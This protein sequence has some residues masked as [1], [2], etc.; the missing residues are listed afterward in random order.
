[1]HPI[2][3]ILTL[4]M[5]SCEAESDC[6]GTP[7]GTAVEDDCAQCTEGTTGLVANNLMDCSGDCGGDAVIDACGVCGG[8]GS[9]CADCAGVPNGDSLVDNCGTCDNDSS[10]D[11]VEDCAG[12]WG[13]TLVD[14]DCGVCDGG[15][16]DD[17]GC[18][19]FEPVALEYWYDS[20]G[21][22]LGAGDESNFHC[23]VDAP[24]NWVSNNDDFEPDCTT[25]NTDSCY[26]CEG[27]IV[28]C[29]DLSDHSL[30][31]NSNGDLYYNSSLPIYGFQIDILSTDIDVT[32]SDLVESSG[33]TISMNS[34]DE[35]TR[36]LAFS[37]DGNSI[38]ETCGVLLSIQGIIGEIE[39]TNLLFSTANGGEIPMVVYDCR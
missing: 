4:V 30:H 13:G 19:C 16:S 38:S 27:D 20:D 14:D 18:G 36:I 11:C 39:I 31:L 33:L 28:Y 26:L 12:T 8:D 17:L 29:E 22:G 5:F 2:L 9:S 25:N 23:L 10:N 15:N 7:G 24:E 32:L 3:L 6:N 21:D 35:F 37:M 1:M 34:N